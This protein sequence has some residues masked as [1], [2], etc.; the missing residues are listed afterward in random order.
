MLRQLMI[1]ILFVCI[2][3]LICNPFTLKRL[4]IP[5]ILFLVLFVCSANQEK[6]QHAINETEVPS[7]RVNTASS[8]GDS[9]KHKPGTSSTNYFWV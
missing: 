3:D 6:N 7:K 5:N 1:L 2:K 4:D 8:E 9:E